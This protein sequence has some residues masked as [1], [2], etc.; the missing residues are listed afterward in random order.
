MKTQ[1]GLTMFESLLLM[2]WQ[3]IEKLYF[4]KQFP[5]G[6]EEKVDHFGLV[7]QKYLEF[8]V[9]SGLMSAK[10]LLLEGKQYVHVME[11]DLQV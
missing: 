4:Q 6:C 10:N 8:V 7:V 11:A 3:N 5:P 2:K 9:F 1:F